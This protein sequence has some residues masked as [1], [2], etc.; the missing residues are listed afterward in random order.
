MYTYTKE[1]GIAV[2]VSTPAVPELTHQIAHVLERPIVRQ[3][4]LMGGTWAER[5]QE[6]HE[7]L[8]RC[9][10]G[11]LVYMQGSGHQERE[12]A[13][14]MIMGSAIPELFVAQIEAIIGSNAG[15]EASGNSFRLVGVPHSVTLR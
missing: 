1:N 14:A 15:P 12:M 10:H 13:A 3:V 2:Y 4:S 11:V 7:E 9:A 8:S 5:E 6:L